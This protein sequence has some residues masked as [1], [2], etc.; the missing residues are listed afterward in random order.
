[1]I[2]CI[3]LAVMHNALHCH[4]DRQHYLRHDR[5]A[6]KQLNQHNL[7]AIRILIGMSVVG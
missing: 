5:F 4:A 7:V 2:H 1:M 3:G 6:D